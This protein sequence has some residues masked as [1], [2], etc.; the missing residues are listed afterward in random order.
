M[1]RLHPL[2]TLVVLLAAWLLPHDARATGWRE[3]LGRPQ[4]KAT[5]IFHYGSAPDQFAELWEPDGHG[6]FPVVVMLH[7]GCWQESIGGVG[8]MAGLAE[9][10]RQRGIAVWNVEYRREGAEGAGYPGTFLDVGDALD[11]LQN[12]A[13]DQGLDLAHVVAL[14]HSAGG[15]LALWAAARGR[16]RPGSP[17]YRRHPQKIQ[18]V[19]SVAGIDDLALYRDQGSPA[20]G[21]PGSIDA[22]VSHDGK[23]SYGDTSPAAMLP[24]HVPQLVVSGTDDEIVPPE[25]GAAYTAAALK[26]GDKAEELVI[27]GAGHIDLIDPDSPGWAQV[28][29]KLLAYL[30][31]SR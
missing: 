11:G 15:Q 12:I 29:A 4:P 3:L 30:K 26:A 10:L 24:L 6:T 8:L 27:K 17:F 19:V 22:L 2:I 14:G 21:V 25:F 5:K 31:Q 16:F 23:N 7:G 9:D 1:N 28:R 13:I 20:C 18:A